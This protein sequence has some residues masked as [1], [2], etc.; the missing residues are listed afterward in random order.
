MH[1]IPTNNS[2]LFTTK[3]ILKTRM[4]LYKLLKCNFI[5]NITTDEVQDVLLLDAKDALKALEIACINNISA[6]ASLKS[7]LPAGRQQ[8]IMISNVPFEIQ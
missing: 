7:S 5:A 3:E 8:E 4:N 6:I 2:Q 1:F